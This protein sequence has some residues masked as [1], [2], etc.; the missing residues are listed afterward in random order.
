MLSRSL[1][2]RAAPEAPAAAKISDLL[3]KTVAMTR[4]LARGLHPVAEEPD[5]LMSALH[6]LAARMTSLFQIDCQFV[7]TGSVQMNDNTAA[8]HLYRIAQEAVSNGV[9]HGHSKH[10]RIGLSSDTESLTL[11]IKDDGIGIGP[12]DPQRQ[13]M[14]LRIM[15]YRAGMIGATLTLEKQQSGGTCVTC[16]LPNESAGAAALQTR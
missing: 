16:T 1:A 7:C 14:G 9:K 2:T 6:D 4:S 12:L 15:H 5:G 3:K 13:G 11:T 8:T 10:V